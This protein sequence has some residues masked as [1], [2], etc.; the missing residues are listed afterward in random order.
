MLIDTLF[1]LEATFS[2][3]NA[4]RASCFTSLSKENTRLLVGAPEPQAKLNL[5]TYY[6]EEHWLSLDG[7]A[8]GQGPHKDDEGSSPYQN[9]RRGGGEFGRQFHVLVQL[10]DHPYSHG[11][12]GN[13]RQLWNRIRHRVMKCVLHDP[14]AESFSWLL[15]RHN[16]IYV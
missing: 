9:I 16:R 10:H 12:N 6:V 15:G 5:G 4:H 11:Q 1:L 8:A 14:T 7:A 2:T 3:D 13:P